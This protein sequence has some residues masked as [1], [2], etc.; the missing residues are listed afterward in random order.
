[1]KPPYLL[2]SLVLLSCTEEKEIPTFR[3]ADAK[4]EITPAP[5]AN[6]EPRPLRWV[7]QETWEEET[8]GQFQIALY[9][10]APGITAAVSRFPGDAGGNAARR[11]NRRGKP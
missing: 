7:A 9:R 1:M 3:I 5:P 8:P 2:L 4:T 10:I 11:W 6:K